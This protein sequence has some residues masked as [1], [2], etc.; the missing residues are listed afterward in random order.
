[1]AF[2]RYRSAFTILKHGPSTPLTLPEPDL[3]FLYLRSA[4]IE[5]LSI[6]LALL[7]LKRYDWLFWDAIETNLLAVGRV[8]ADF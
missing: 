4:D 1:M 6:M 3:I 7:L 5:L 2:R 8:M